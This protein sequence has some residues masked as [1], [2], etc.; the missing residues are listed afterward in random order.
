MNLFVTLL[1]SGLGLAAHATCPAVTWLDLGG[2]QADVDR[3]SSLV[4]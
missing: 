3:F 2:A 1:L 4:E